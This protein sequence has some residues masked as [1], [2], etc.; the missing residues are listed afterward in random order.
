MLAA[1]LAAFVL[2]SLCDIRS[3][4]G[5]PEANPLFR[6]RFGKFALRRN[7]A[8]TAAY[9]ALGT[10]AALAFDWA[11]DAVAF[12]F[13]FGGA[14]RCAVAAKNRGV[15]RRLADWTRRERGRMIAKA[16]RVRRGRP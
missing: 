5:L 1:A 15:R 4:R 2:G 10:G 14:V 9:A 11:Y 3:S 6:D 12:G 8:V 13:F 7:V 16:E